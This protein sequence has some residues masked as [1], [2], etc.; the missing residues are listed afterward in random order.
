MTLHVICAAYKRIIPLRI[1]ID[2]FLVQTNPNWKLYIIHDG[3]MP[4]AV[5]DIIK[6]YDDERIKVYSTETRNGHSGFGNRDMMMKGIKGEDGDYVMSTNDDN[7]YVPIFVDEMLKIGYVQPGS[8]GIGIIYCNMI[9]S[10]FGYTVLSTVLQVYY[11]DMGA[12]A[13]LLPLAKKVGIKALD[14]CADGKFAQDCLA[15]CNA[16][17]LITVKSEKIMFIH[18]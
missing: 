14:D 5:K 18:N 10:H 13:V 11:I 16:T 15:E 2:S 7:Y 3:K 1:L 6:L 4:E 17:G 8:P 9:H 12:F